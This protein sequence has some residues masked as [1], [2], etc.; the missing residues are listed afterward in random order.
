MHG[1]RSK[2]TSEKSRQQQR[3]GEGFSSG[4]KRLISHSD[5]FK[6]YRLPPFHLPLQLISLFRVALTDTVLMN[7]FCKERNLGMNIGE[8]A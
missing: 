5:K 8:L 6:L 3:C 7:K 2:I 1:S 4:V